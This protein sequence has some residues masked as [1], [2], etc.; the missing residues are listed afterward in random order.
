[1]TRAKLRREKGLVDGAIYLGACVHLNVGVVFPE[2][3]SPCLEGF[4]CRQCRSV[5]MRSDM[6]GLGPRLEK[7]NI[8]VC[9]M[10]LGG[11]ATTGRG[12]CA[13]EF[14]SRK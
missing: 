14:N 2:S 8:N 4:S 5:G 12:G 13:D 10:G 11:E 6:S 7:R 9:E 3:P 1:M